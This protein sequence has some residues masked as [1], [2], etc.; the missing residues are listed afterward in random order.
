MA[1]LAL[2]NIVVITILGNIVMKCLKD[3]LSQKKD[4]KD[5]VFSA[6]KLGIE[7]AELWDE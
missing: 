2:I 5:P 7:N 1:I 4:G 3:Y 6:K